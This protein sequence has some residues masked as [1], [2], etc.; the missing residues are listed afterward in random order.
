MFVT[1]LG[2]VRFGTKKN[3]LGFWGDMH[4]APD[5]EYYFVFAYLQYVKRCYF[6][7]VH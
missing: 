7:S 5:W 4:S 6:T 1:V 2:M 3:Q